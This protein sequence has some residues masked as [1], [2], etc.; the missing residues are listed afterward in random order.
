MKVSAII[1]SMVTMAR[2]STWKIA[3]YGAEHGTPHFHIETRRS[4]CTVGI[5]S[6]VVIVGSV[7]VKD[8]REALDWARANRAV[9]LAQWKALN[10]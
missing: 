2:G 6:L 9:L 1:G 8:L 10:R 3:V 7:P 4:R 5:Q